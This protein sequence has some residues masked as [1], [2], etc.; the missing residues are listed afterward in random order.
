MVHP[1]VTQVGR[2]ILDQKAGRDGF[3]TDEPAGFSATVACTPGVEHHEEVACGL[4]IFDADRG[5]RL[6]LDDC[7]YSVDRHPSG[8]FRFGFKIGS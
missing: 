6:R 7:S 8:R 1:T 2:L 3:L 4:A 5:E